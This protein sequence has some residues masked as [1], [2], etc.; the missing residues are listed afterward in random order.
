MANDRDTNACWLRTGSVA[1][2]EL[3]GWGSAFRFTDVLR[4]AT[5]AAFF[6]CPE[7][8]NWF[9]S[10]NDNPGRLAPATVLGLAGGGM[11]ALGLIATL[12]MVMIAL[13]GP[14]VPCRTV[15]VVAATATAGPERASASSS[16]FS[17]RILPC[18]LL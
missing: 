18:S 12:G 4:A 15:T 13:A 10:R 17:W 16:R 6:T 5:M 1:A 11:L 3:V 9:W 2:G 8:A 14:S 7:G